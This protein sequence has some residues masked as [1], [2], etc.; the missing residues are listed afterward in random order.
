M[1]PPSTIAITTKANDPIRP[2]RVAKST[3]NSPTCDALR[4]TNVF[5]R[6]TSVSAPSK[7]DLAQISEK[8]KITV[9]THTLMC[10]NLTLPSHYVIFPALSK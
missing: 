4:K 9:L 10:D 7:I 1:L 5:Y 6:T 8:V 3:R 2:I